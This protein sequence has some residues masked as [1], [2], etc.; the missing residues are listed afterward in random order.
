MHPKNVRF[1]TFLVFWW[2][3]LESRVMFVYFQNKSHLPDLFWGNVEKCAFFIIE[4]NQKTKN[5]MNRT[6]WDKYSWKNNCIQILLRFIKIF[7]QRF[8]LGPSK[9]LPNNVNHQIQIYWSDKKCWQIWL[10]E[11]V[12]VNMTNKF[13]GSYC[14][15]GWTFKTLS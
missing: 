10:V 6:G 2:I 4:K 12:L 15:P 8:N 14:G 5:V 1:I 9:S 3:W 13:D 7:F 11:I